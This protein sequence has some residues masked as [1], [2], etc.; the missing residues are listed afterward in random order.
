MSEFENEVESTESGAPEGSSPEASESSSEQSAAP[1]AKPETDTTPFHEHPRFKELVEQKNEFSKRYQDME[2]R[3]KQ[4]ESQLNSFKESQPKAPT[5]FDQLIKDL[6]QVDPRLAG[7][8][9]AQAKAAEQAK[10]LQERLDRWEQTQQQQSHQQ[11]LQTAVSK[12]N[13]LHE[14]NKM[15]DFGKQFINN[16]L[17]IAYRS[18]QL[19]ANDLRAVETAYAETAKVIKAY[20]ENL[21]RDLTKSYVQD[22]KKDASVPA[23]VPKGT[24]AKP[25][26]KPT[27]TYKSKDELRAAVVKAY[28]KEASANK[29]AENS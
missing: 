2:S 21:K 18:G 26:Q 5:E 29:Q 12:I 15:S 19:K 13:S 14:T 28:S 8:L 22:K 24:Q 7:A 4:I 17:D 3:Y 20:E 6:K 16:Q 10:A 23:S 1:A 27:P 11:T 25:G 9:E